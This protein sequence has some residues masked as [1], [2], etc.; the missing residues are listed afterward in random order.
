MDDSSKSESGTDDL[1]VVGSSAGGVGALSTLVSTLPRSFPAPLVLA[2]HLDPQRPSHLGSILERR[3]TLPILVVGEDEPTKLERGKIY[4][5]PANRHVKIVDGHVQLEG[6]QG[7][8]PK[9]SVDLL[10]SSA[11]QSYREHLVAVIL[12]GSGSDGAAGAVDVKNAGGVVIIQNPQTAAYPSMPLSLP[13]TAVD[14]V[15]E[16][17]LIGPLL[18]DLLKGVDLPDSPDTVHDPLRDLLTHVSGQ[19]NIDFRNYKSST[20]LRRIARRMAVTHNTTIKNYA[21]FVRSHPDEVKELVRAFL[22]KVTGFFRD[23]EAFEVIKT[24]IIPE[25]IDRGRENGRTLRLWSAGCATGEEPYSLAMLVANHLGP[26]FSDWNVKVFATDLAPDAIAFARR[27][28]YPENVL[29]D[30]PEDFRLRY[31]ERID[32]GFRVSKALRQVVIFGQQDISRGVPFPR[33]DLVTCRNLLIYLKPDLQQVVLDLFA[34]SLHQSHGYLFL[35]KAETARPTKATFE[36]VNKK[37]KIYRCLG[38]PRG[39]PVQE[40][41][42]PAGFPDKSWREPRRPPLRVVAASAPV[43]DLTAAELD[44]NQLRRL[45]ETM[46]RHTNVA[47]VIIDRQYRILTINAAARRMLGI[48]DLA[49]DQDFLHTVRSMPYQEVRRAIDTCFREHSTMQLEDLELDETFEGSGKYVS[50]TI[51][52]MQI[53]QGAPELAVITVLDVTNQVHTRK[54]LD[55]VQREHAELVT[56]LSAA[57][58]RFSA[59]NKELQDANEELQAANEELMLTQ[60]E[61]Q[62]TNEEFEATNEE[63]QATNEELETNNEELQATNEELQTTNDELSARTLELQ[64][65]TRQHRLEQLQLATLL[66]R[67]PHYIMVLNA[68]DLTVQAINPAYT[69]LFGGR[70]VQGLPMSDVFSGKHVEDLIK[71]LRTAARDSVTVNTDPIIASVD[72]EHDGDKA[73]FIHTIVPIS[74]ASGTNVTRLFLYSEKVE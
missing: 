61:L 13:P 43:R 52:A 45:N 16:L 34:Y 32:H 21:D 23:A 71:L 62:A 41:S 12:T 22:I 7:D 65:L 39:F 6:D 50:L 8:R 55:A 73:R 59:M 37:W 69:Q 33:I 11:A 47:V 72:G 15:V 42:L 29:T 44:I 5:V 40:P 30:L 70:N 24:S 74:D 27:G 28:L 26:E 60:E 1:V 48:R 2:Q 57:N 18:Y 10:L 14:H 17:E 38:G 3:S 56:E 58:K 63:L 35:G 53:E 66:E 9:P 54:R 36:L 20:I 4:V 31:F 64:E 68:D 46:L 67:F 25:L 51:V 19:T 49:Y